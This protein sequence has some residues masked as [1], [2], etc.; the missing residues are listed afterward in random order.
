[1]RRQIRRP[2]KADDIEAVARSSYRETDE[3]LFRIYFYDCPPFT[4]RAKH[5]ITE[6][7]VDFSTEPQYGQ[8]LTLYEQISLKNCF[9]FRKGQLKFRSWTMKNR[10]LKRILRE[11]PPTSDWR[12]V[13]DFKQKGVDIK[14][15]LDISW[16]ASKRIVDRIILF[17]GDTD[18]IPAMKFARREGVQV[19]VAA[20][21]DSIPAVLKEHADEFR[22][23]DVSFLRT[24]Q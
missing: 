17:T 22:L 5:P 3:D 18:F 15:G 6:R 4:G 13:P 19:V 8:R 7:L 2:I 16:L 1:M 20:F 10:Q 24:A 11:S 12:L 23:V 21:V 14:I 9:A